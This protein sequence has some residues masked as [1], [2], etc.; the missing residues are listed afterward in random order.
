LV[1][2]IVFFVVLIKLIIK[3]SANIVDTRTRDSHTVMARNKFGG[4]GLALRV[5]P[6]LK[7][8]T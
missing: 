8:V 2:F 6:S 7:R 1:I 3:I 5:S 4:G